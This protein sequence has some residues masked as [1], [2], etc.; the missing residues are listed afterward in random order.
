V[1]VHCEVYLSTASNTFGLHQQVIADAKDMK[2]LYEEESLIWDATLSSANCVTTELM[3]ILSHLSV[4][5]TWRPL[6]LQVRVMTSYPHK[7]FHLGYPSYS[8]L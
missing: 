7:V 3:D 2:V 8:V 5:S 6:Q 1:G 4:F